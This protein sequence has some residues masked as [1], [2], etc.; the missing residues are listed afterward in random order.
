MREMCL[1]RSEAF[2]T[3][4]REQR[5]FIRA[6]QGLCRNR[7]LYFDALSQKNAMLHDM[8]TSLQ[9]K[10]D[11][12][13]MFDKCISDWEEE[14]ASTECA[15]KHKDSSQH[16]DAY[17]FYKNQ[18]IS[19]PMGQGT[20]VKI[21]TMEEKVVVQ[22]PF[23]LMHC[24]FESVISWA[25]SPRN[26]I[27]TLDSNHAD[28][29]RQR[30][31]REL[32]LPSAT[33]GMSDKRIA[34][35]NNLLERSPS[36]TSLLGDSMSD[37][38]L[39]AKS[40]VLSRSSSR[41]KN[42]RGADRD[43]AAISDQ[44]HED[45]SSTSHSE[46]PAFT[47]IESSK[48]EIYLNQTLKLP[49]LF[50]PP[51]IAPYLVS[52]YGGNNVTSAMSQIGADVRPAMPH[53]SY[54]TE[55]RAEYCFKAFHRAEV[56]DFFCNIDVNE[57]VDDDCIPYSQNNGDDIEQLPGCRLHDYAERVEHLKG[58]LRPLLRKIKECRKRKQNF[59]HE[60]QNMKLSS[61]R[62]AE[63]IS[64]M[65]LGMFTRRVLQR[66]NAALKTDQMLNRKDNTTVKF[67]S[68]CSEPENSTSAAGCGLSSAENNGDSISSTR[69]KS[70]RSSTVA[71]S[72]S[73]D[74]LASS[75]SKRKKD[76]VSK[77]DETVRP[78]SYVVPPSANTTKTSNAQNSTSTKRNPKRLR[79]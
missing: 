74:A 55:Q 43:A 65:R 27:C 79:R 57:N 29:L 26:T 13:R 50:S 10:R 62:T 66:Q 25:P 17:Y 73:S 23:G 52:T 30:W 32:T 75:R 51:G 63:Q 64:N 18:E 48:R 53:T 61:A 56:V 42:K 45:G 60:V 38:S 33:V 40:S 31:A 22:L 67:S 20:I 39:K 76:E 28:G 7:C 34:E 3:K 71:T 1:S 8:I 78:V 35:I 59:A 68:S 37:D 19:T 9:Q 46:S 14:S 4:K 77:E 58:Y 15:R 49:L 12:L 44:S 36:P 5:N 16:D 11:A 24:T 6:V 2:L 21:D 70:T 72:S 47:D 41:V 69:R 54:A